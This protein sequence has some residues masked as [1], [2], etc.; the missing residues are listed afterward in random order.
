MGILEVK[1]SYSCLEVFLTWFELNICKIEKIMH[2]FIQR[3]KLAL[4][5]LNFQN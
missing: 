4:L 3:H 5:K 2:A 1:F